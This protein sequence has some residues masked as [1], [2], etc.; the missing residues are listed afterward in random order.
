MTRISQANFPC[1]FSQS[2]MKEFVL[3]TSNKIIDKLH[4][5]LWRKRNFT[6]K[7]DKII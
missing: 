4:R 6:N 5:T 1:R 7:D 2:Q 3:L